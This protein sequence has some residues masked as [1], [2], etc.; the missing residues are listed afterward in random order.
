MKLTEPEAHAIYDILAKEAG[1]RDGD[2][3]QFVWAHTMNDMSEYRFQGAL[4]FGGKFWCKDSW[5]VT[6]YPEDENPERWA[7]ILRVNRQLV[8]LQQVVVLHRALEQVEWAAT[9]VIQVKDDD[10]VVAYYCPGCGNHRDP[11]RAHHPEC[12][13]RVAL[14]GTP[15]RLRPLQLP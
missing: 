1:A 10:D 6:A 9:T 12:P 13:I 11:H 14:Q 5:R 3:E 15:L 4:G 7:I 2:R 8:R